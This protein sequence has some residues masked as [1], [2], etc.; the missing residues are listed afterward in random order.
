M[1]INQIA[2][3]ITLTILQNKIADQSPEQFVATY[4][5]TLQKVTDAV[6]QHKRDNRPKGRVVSRD[7]IS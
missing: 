4:F 3:D 2:H 7:T 6:I 1:E 5:E